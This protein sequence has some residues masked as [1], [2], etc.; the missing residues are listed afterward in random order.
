MST[1]A[2]MT[3]ILA[4][5]FTL[6]AIVSAVITVI[7]IV[8]GDTRILHINFIAIICCGTSAAE[9]WVI[10]KQQKTSQK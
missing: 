5:I 1:K 3:L 8:N 4:I 10:F 6:L 2:K 7:N 9:K